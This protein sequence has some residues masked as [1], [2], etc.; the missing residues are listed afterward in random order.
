[1]PKAINKVEIFRI[2]NLYYG[3]GLTQEKIAKLMNISRSQVSRLL[4]RAVELGI[5]KFDVSIPTD[6]DYEEL[7]NNLSSELKLAKIIIAPVEPELDGNDELI[8]TAIAKAAAKHLDGLLKD[9][10]NIGIGWGRT[11]Y[12]T[13]LLLEKHKTPSSKV[14]VPLLGTSGDNV[15]SLQINS[16]IDRFSERYN[17]QGIYTNMLTIRDASVRLSQTEQKRF[18]NLKKLWSRLDVAVFGLGA[19]PKDENELFSELSVG[20]I[21]SITNSGIV[22]DI[23]A[24][25]FCSD[26][27]VFYDKQQYTLTSYDISLLASLKNSVCLAGGDDKVDGIIAA[28]NNKYF[29]TLI[30]DS[31]TAKKLLYALYT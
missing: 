16:I 12:E 21:D 25:F 8:R 19:K 24:Q 5:V 1:M 13:S 31:L 3:H 20:Y 11:V 17:A 26:G 29:K 2:A 15:P 9:C 23:L 6:M 18:D 10:K 27:M 30:T 7:A 14:F 22:A 28:A 4:E